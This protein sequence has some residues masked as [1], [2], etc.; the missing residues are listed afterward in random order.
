MEQLLSLICLNTHPQHAHTLNG[1][2]KYQEIVTAHPRQRLPYRW[3]T[4]QE[5]TEGTRTKN[6]D[7]IIFF[8]QESIAMQEIK[9]MIRQ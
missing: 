6:V 4:Y 5:N 1:A 2:N 7:G 3:Q 9:S 8:I